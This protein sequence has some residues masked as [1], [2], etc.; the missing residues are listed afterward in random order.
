MICIIEG[1][2]IDHR[3]DNEVDVDSECVVEHGTEE[4]KESEDVTDWN[5]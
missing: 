1:S 3:G 2:V 4:G 5:L